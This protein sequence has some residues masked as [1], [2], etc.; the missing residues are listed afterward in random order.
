MAAIEADDTSVR[1]QPPLGSI[2]GI[3]DWDVAND[4]NRA[5]PGCAEL[6]GLSPAKA[7][8]GLGLDAYLNAVHPD[9]VGGLSRKIGTALK[10][11]VLEAEY[12]IIMDNRIKWVFARGYCTLDPS[13]RPERLPGAIVGL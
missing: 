7:A 11:G 5:D 1:L 10:G 4:R 8:A 13:N 2:V 3:W 12:R 6:F 9:D